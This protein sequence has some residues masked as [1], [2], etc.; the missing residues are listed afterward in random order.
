MGEELHTYFEGRR[1]RRWAKRIGRGL[2]RTVP[3]LADHALAISEPGVESLRALGCAEVSYVPPGVDPDE[4][5]ETRPA[6]LPPGPWV[7]YAGN[8]DRYQDLDV[9]IEAMRDVPQA[10]LLMVSAA[11]LDDWA[12]CGLLRLSW[13]RRIHLTRCGPTS[14]RAACR[15]PRTVCSGYPI[16]LLNYLGMGLPT[17]A[18]RGRR[19]NCSAWLRCRT[20]TPRRPPPSGRC[21]RTRRRRRVG[22]AARTHVLSACT[23]D[24]RAGELESVYWKVLDGSEACRTVL[25]EAMMR[26]S[27]VDCLERSSD[28]SN[29]FP[30]AL[31]ALLLLAG[32]T[33]TEEEFGTPGSGGG[34]GVMTTPM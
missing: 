3:R 13:C 16:K 14:R 31:I 32:C 34:G 20:M 21:W 22:A 5:P 8:P 17:V 28:G 10:G 9:L 19:R 2:D 11:P 12:D 29:C 25:A 15:L 7:V 1:V 6:P 4:L 18:A 33:G 27:R 24:A 26:P 30:F 23:W